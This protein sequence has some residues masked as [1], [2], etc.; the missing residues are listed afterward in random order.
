MIRRLAGMRIIESA[1]L[2]EPGE[3]RVERRTWRERLWSRPWRP[4]VA[5]RTVIP[6]V[7]HRGALRLSD[8]TL[9]MHPAT[10]K[11]LHDTLHGERCQQ[12]GGPWP[13]E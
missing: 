11:Q 3:P 9:V 6:Q 2:M 13:C 4:W 8:G 5:T 12:C 10:V 7:P 1:Y